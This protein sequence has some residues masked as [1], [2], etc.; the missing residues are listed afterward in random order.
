LD[1]DLSYLI[2]YLRSNI[3]E[4][5]WLFGLVK[6]NDGALSLPEPFVSF[7][8]NT[9][10]PRWATYYENPALASLLPL[11]SLLGADKY[12]Q[13][14]NELSGSTPQQTSEKLAQLQGEILQSPDQFGE[15]IK[16]IESIEH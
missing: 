5:S 13:L 6:K 10:K 1:E 8:S 9:N 3:A 4:Y 12:Q 14:R 2:S 16:L 15:D 7:L 11:V